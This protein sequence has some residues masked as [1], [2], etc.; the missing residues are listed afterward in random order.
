MAVIIPPLDLS[1]LKSGPLLVTG[2][3]GFKG[4]W[5]TLLLE[6]LGIEVIGLSLPA[7]DQSLYNRLSRIGKI[8]EFF[9]DVRSNDEIQAALRKIRPANVLH[10]AAQPLVLNSY[11]APRETF[12]TNVMG[13]VNLLDAC[14]QVESVQKIGI[15]TTD[16]VYKNTNAN[17]KHTEDDPLLGFEPYSASKVAAENVAI[18]WR[19]I[20]SQKDG[21]VI[22]TYRAGNVIGG[23]DFAK[24][25]LLPDIVRAIQENSQLEIR[26]P[27]STRP[28]QHVL[29]PLSGY[30][31]AMGAVLPSKTP[32]SLNFGPRERELSV[33]E[34]VEIAQSKT[35]H[36]LRVKIVNDL[37]IKEESHLALD[38]QLALRTLGW[39]PYWD[40]R[41]AVLETIEWWNKVN[42]GI[43]AEEACR[44][45]I[46][47][48]LSKF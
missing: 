38:S 21:P 39:S 28:W 48:I 40:Q 36:P 37:T 13:T 19:R 1:T 7:L 24:N 9:V 41:S 14:C 32:D 30:L 2:H 22:Q 17:I 34:V 8:Q 15:I 42:S 45:D 35:S 44:S 10:L 43:S 23:G 12:E 27:A 26:N 16:K 6:N 3:T 46:E 18:A 25:R 20:L 4:T 47:K 31:R 5:L 11:K 29:D 33:Q